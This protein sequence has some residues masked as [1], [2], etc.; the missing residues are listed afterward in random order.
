[1]SRNYFFPKSV[2]DFRDSLLFGKWQHRTS[3]MGRCSCVNV[4]TTVSVSFVLHG[5]SF[6]YLEAKIIFEP[7]TM[8]IYSFF[9]E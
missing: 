5:A 2:L 3:S 1:M 9:S 6:L 8:V 4:F 7:V